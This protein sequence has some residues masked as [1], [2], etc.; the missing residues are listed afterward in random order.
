[1]LDNDALLA[2]LA[3]RPVAIVRDVADA[4]RAQL[5]FVSPEDAQALGLP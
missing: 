5:V 3:G 2:L 4:S 1:V